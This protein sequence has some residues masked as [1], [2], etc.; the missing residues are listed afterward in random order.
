MSKPRAKTAE[1]VREEFVSH[2]RMLARYW[3]NV[4]GQ[5]VE[6]KCEGVAFSI[7]VTIDGGS[8]ELPAF[9]MIPA[10]HEDDKQY[11][12]DNDENWYEKVVVNDCQLHEMFHQPEIIK[13]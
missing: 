6:E 3:A 1:E 13:E 10:P 9:D 4:S 2:V 5:T 11:Y 8:A 7:L 12:I